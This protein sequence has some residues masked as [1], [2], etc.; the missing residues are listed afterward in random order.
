MENTVLSNHVIKSFQIADEE[1][2]KIKC[3]LEP[4]CVAYNFGPR[5]ELGFHLCELSERNHLQALPN[6]LQVKYGFIYRP[7][8]MVSNLKL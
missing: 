7:I 4:D 2:C 1:M 5:N 8:T 3:F 6:D